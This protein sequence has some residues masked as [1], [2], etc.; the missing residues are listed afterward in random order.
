MRSILC[1]QYSSSASGNKD[2]IQYATQVLNIDSPWKVQFESDIIKRGPADI[3]TFNQLSDWSQNDDMRIKYFSGT[4]NYQS[5]FVLENIPDGKLYIDLG[6]VYVTA[7]V[8]INGQCVGGVWTA[9]YRVDITE[10]VRIGKNDVEVEV[11][12]TWINRI[13]GDRKL[14]ENERRVVTHTS[15]WRADAPLQKSGLLGPVRVLGIH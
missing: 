15:P 11:V 12:N 5:E 2:N 1:C 8:K 6:E 14:P 7:K 4:A 9:P 13:L 3:I 10:A